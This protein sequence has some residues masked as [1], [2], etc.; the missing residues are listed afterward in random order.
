MCPSGRVILDYT[1]IG[2]PPLRLTLARS[3]GGW[4]SVTDQD[5]RLFFPPSELDVCVKFMRAMERK[6]DAQL[7]EASIAA[8]GYSVRV[9]DNVIPIRKGA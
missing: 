3:R 9:P 6:R 7:D 4:Y 5:G 8:A 1:Q 2:T